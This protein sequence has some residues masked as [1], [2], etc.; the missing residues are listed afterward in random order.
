MKKLATIFLSLGV[1]FSV[2]VAFSSCEL[3]NLTNFLEKLNPVKKTTVTEEEWNEA[4]DYSDENHVE[5]LEIISTVGGEENKEGYIIKSEVDKVE[6]IYTYTSNGEEYGDKSWASLEDGDF[7]VYEEEIFQGKPT[8]RYVKTLEKNHSMKDLTIAS[9]IKQEFAMEE[10][11]EYSSYT[12]DE[13]TKAYKADSIL[14]DSEKGVSIENCQFKFENGKL[15]YGSLERDRLDDYFNEYTVYCE[16][17][18]TY[19]NAKVELP[20]NIVEDE[21]EEESVSVQTQ[22]NESAWNAALTLGENYTIDAK[23]YGFVEDNRM[24]ISRDGSNY[25]SSGRYSDDDYVEEYVN[26]YGTSSE[27]YY[28]AYGDLF[29]YSYTYVNDDCFRTEISKKNYEQLDTALQVYFLPAEL[30]NYNDYTYDENTKAY[31]ANGNISVG[32]VTVKN[33][34]IAFKNGKLVSVFYTILDSDGSVSETMVAFSYGNTEIDLP[35][36]FQ[37]E[38]IT[39]CDT[40]FAE[41]D[42]RKAEDYGFLWAN[43]TDYTKELRTFMYLNG[44]YEN[45]TIIKE[46][47]GLTKTDDNLIK[48]KT[49]STSYVQENGKY[50]KEINTTEWTASTGTTVSDEKTE[51]T[52]EQY[53]NAISVEDNLPFL[54]KYATIENYIFEGNKIVGLRYKLD[55]QEYEATIFYKYKDYKDIPYPKIWND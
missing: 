22:V 50:Y 24:I 19:G 52:E 43:E 4:F 33:S 14:I 49:I 55:G 41:S 36:N 23:S 9:L 44:T 31:I 3:S 26:Y 12:Y 8:D 35:K 10:I 27:E 45:T 32:D 39:E 53:R 34:R 38:S 7:Y 20:T 16:W 29:Y 37:T 48:R 1:C 28:K 18:L 51:I 47:S 21:A 46:Y 40:F 2:S 25:Y 11:F 6:V 15:V 42:I 54:S 13:T 17:N 30:Y 5:T